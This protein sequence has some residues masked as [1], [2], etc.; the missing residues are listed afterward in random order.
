MHE[1]IDPR[2]W[3]CEREL[4][5]PPKHFVTTKAKL[6]EES[7]QWVLDTL[8]GRFAVTQNNDNMFDDMFDS[9]GIVSFEDPREA[10]IY[11][12]KWS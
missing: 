1:Y 12:L 10:M 8:C 2:I 4:L 11:E 7:K 5:Y 9:I 6:T 3:F